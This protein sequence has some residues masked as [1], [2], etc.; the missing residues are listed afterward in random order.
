[1]GTAN[2][3]IICEQL[4]ELAQLLYQRLPYK[5]V[6]RHSSPF[7]TL[8]TNLHITPTSKN[9]FVVFSFPLLLLTPFQKKR[10]AFADPHVEHNSLTLLLVLDLVLLK[11]G[12]FRHLLYNWGSEPRKAL[13]SG[14]SVV[15]MA[16]NKTKGVLLVSKLAVVLIFLNVRKSVSRSHF[17]FSLVRV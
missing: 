9:V 6:P 11:R 13:N 1:M 4:W 12:M 15:P 5:L 7:S 3:C 10:H 8:S 2:V 14:K 17:D 16:Q